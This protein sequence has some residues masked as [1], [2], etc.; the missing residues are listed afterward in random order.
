M[1][2]KIEKNYPIPPKFTGGEEIKE[3]LKKMKSGD[4][5]FLEDSKSY[6]RW[7]D[8]AKIFGLSITRRSVMEAGKTGIRI[9]ITEE[10]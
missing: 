5:V 1:N 7:R 10:K 4:S 3:C 2:Y 8:K 9:W 6:Y